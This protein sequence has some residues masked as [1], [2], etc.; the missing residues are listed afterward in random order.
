MVLLEGGGWPEWVFGT[1][2]LSGLGILGRLG[3]ESWRSA[4]AERQRAEWL[5]ATRPSTVAEHAVAL[6]RARLAGEVEECIRDALR[7]VAVEI[8]H[9]D[10][11][12]PVPALQRVHALTRRTT[13]EL[14]RQLGL[15]REAGGEEVARGS[16]VSPSQRRVVDDARWPRA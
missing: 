3:L 5:G 10:E 6:E 1:F 2:M 13:S 15:L 12:S 4:R 8:E 7:Q 14:R 16:G 11:T 9:L